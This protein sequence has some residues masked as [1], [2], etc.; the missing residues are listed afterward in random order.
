M[1]RHLEK[2]GVTFLNSSDGIETVKDKLYIQQALAQYYLPI[3]KT[4]LAEN[5]IN[6]D[7]IEEGIGFPIVVKTLNGTH[8]CGFFAETRRNFEQLVEKIDLVDIGLNM[9]LQ[10]FVKTS[11]GRN[12]RIIVIGGRVVVSMKDKQ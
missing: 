6:V 4:M 8:G 5:S 3:P 10:E 9:I 11:F 12:I 7:Y 2:M 1:F